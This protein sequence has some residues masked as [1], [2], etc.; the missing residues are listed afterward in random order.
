MGGAKSKVAPHP[1]RERVS[2]ITTTGGPAVGNAAR[3]S[4]S[5]HREALVL[6]AAAT[7]VQSSQT[8]KC[9]G[10]SF[11]FSPPTKGKRKKLGGV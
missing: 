9:Q 7:S 11:E 4:G 1:A 6:S 10:N 3:S 2:T 5:N 8:L